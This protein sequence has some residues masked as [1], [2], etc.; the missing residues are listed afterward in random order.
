MKLQKVSLANYRG[1]EQLDVAFDSQVTV[2][3]GVNGVGKSGLLHALTVL[4]SHAMPKITASTAKP[5]S[6]EFSDIRVGK[7]SHVVSL[8]YELQKNVFHELYQY[9]PEGMSIHGWHLETTGDESTKEPSDKAH[10][11]ALEVASALKQLPNQPLVIYF[12]TRRQ[13][14]GTIK[15]IPKPEPYTVKQAYIGAVNDREVA[16]RDFVAWFHA[17]EVLAEGSENSSKREKTLARI[18]EVVTTF[19]PEFKNLRIEHD[20]VR[21]VVDKSG[22]ALA[23]NQLSDGERGVLAILFD[24]TRRLSIANPELEDPVSDGQA[25][26][27]IDEIELHLH[28]V[29][30]RQVIDRF[31]DTFK[32]CQFVATTHSPLLLGEVEAKSVRFLYH[33]DGRVK[34]WTPSHA[35]GLDVNRILEEL[36]DVKTRDSDVEKKLEAIFRSIDKEQFKDAKQ[37]IQKLA[38]VIGESDPELIRAK[39]MIAFLEGIE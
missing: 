12:S 31:T 13:L 30:Q 15:T 16:L 39:S 38:E 7:A 21:M 24:I 20:P 34:C 29:W 19:L 4:F 25:I 5:I 27:L 37:K 26:V 36:M 6:F 18:R 35:L 28:P 11:R 33:E 32:N 1:F 14:P 17:Q 22:I 23:I 10:A 9:A 8:E 2:V 3:A